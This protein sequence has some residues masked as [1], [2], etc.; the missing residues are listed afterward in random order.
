MGWKQAVRVHTEPGGEG[1]QRALADT[2]GCEESQ[3]SQ[4]LQPLPGDA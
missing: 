2:T 3:V 4:P 1:L